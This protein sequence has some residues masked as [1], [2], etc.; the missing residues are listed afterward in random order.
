[1]GTL[2]VSDRNKG[3]GEWR[4]G[5]PLPEG[6]LPHSSPSLTPAPHS[7]LIGEDGLVYEGRGWTTKGA[8][9]GKSWN[10]ISIGI[11]FMG[12]YMGEWPSSQSGEGA[13]PGLGDSMLWGR[14]E[15]A[16]SKLCALVQVTLLFRVAFPPLGNNHCDH[17]VRMRIT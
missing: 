17:T 15:T 8:H 7:F 1:M 6:P 2:C 10:A 12:N 5:S 11:T 16:T 9:S 14:W 13:D 4:R 3:R